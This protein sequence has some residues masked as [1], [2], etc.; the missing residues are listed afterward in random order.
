MPVILSS[1]IGLIGTTISGLFNFKG[2]QAK[3]VQDSLEVLKSIDDNDSKSVVALSNAM[4]AILTNGSLL[5]RNWRA[6]LMS[7]CVAILICSY[8][9]Y[10][11][12]HFNQPLTPMMAQVLELIK[13][14][15]GGYIVKG[16]VVEVARMFNIAQVIKTFI[17]KRL[18]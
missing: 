4:N 12:P 3:T 15:L 5:E 17:E 8:F 13:I 16:G 14:G 10:V 7:V 18:I 9:G 2:E 11:P 6:V 1:I